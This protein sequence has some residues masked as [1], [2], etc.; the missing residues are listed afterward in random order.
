VRIIGQGAAFLPR[1]EG[2]ELPPPRRGNPMSLG[3]PRFLPMAVLAAAAFALQLPPAAAAPEGPASAP[4]APAPAPAPAADD[5]SS[6]AALRKEMESTYLEIQKDYDALAGAHAAETL[7]ALDAAVADEAKGRPGVSIEPAEFAD[8]W[9]KRSLLGPVVA[10]RLAAKL[11]EATAKLA[12]EKP[13]TAPT[14]AEAIRLAAKL[15]FP[16]AT[17]ADNWDRHFTDL[18]VVQRWA[19]AKGA[20]PPVPE[21]PKTVAVADPADMVLVPRG[22]LAVPDQRGR[23]WPQLGVKAEK[24]TVKS[25]YV[26]RT[27]VSGAAYA[28]FLRE[29]KDAKLRERVL[30]QGWK[31]D[32]KGVP[33]M[34]EAAAALPVTGIPYE[35]AAAF[36]ASLG[37]RLPYED[38][39]ERAARGNAGLKYP[40]GNEWTD[41]SAV[42]GGKPGPAPTGSTGGDR[43][44]WGVLDMAGNVSELCA[45]YPDGK[46]VKGLP[47]ETDQV[48]IRGGNFKESPDEAAN[49]WR[50]VVGAATRSDRIGF[51]CAMDEKEYEK[52]YGKR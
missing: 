13:G 35:G 12:E 32:D 49:D 39:W 34:P 25:F 18:D 9:S 8:I 20:T 30:P 24:R 36:A 41:G 38:E 52:R 31:V 43:S 40:W 37:K 27:E 5:A 23:G 29:I 16:E 44:S 50:Y 11:P 4:P 33:A 42:A 2:A 48:I 21:P 45:T 14:T 3:R 7:A 51:R 22:D 15:V 47:K 28:K 26:D 46:P 6:I 1:G 17:M 10:R 19:K